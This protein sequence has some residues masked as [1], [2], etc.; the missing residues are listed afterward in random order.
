MQWHRRHQQATHSQRLLPGKGVRLKR[1]S[2]GTIVNAIP[3]GIGGVKL[4][5]Y[6]FKVMDEDFIV[7]RTWD[8]T[9]EGDK[10]I[11]I[12][13]PTKLRF[14]IDTET[15]DGI[16]GTYTAYDTTTQTRHASFGSPAVEE[17]Q[18]IV[19]RYLVDDE[20]Y[21]MPART[22]IVDDDGKDLGLIDINVDG[23]AWASTS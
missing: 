2:G 9:N 23:R 16:V 4:S 18:V 12:A 1:L 22:L 8:G 14:S 21:V 13:K 3:R 6:R 5:L 11:L 17:D 7:C 19:P 10:D 20:I 15:I